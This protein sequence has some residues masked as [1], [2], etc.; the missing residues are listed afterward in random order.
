MKN[1][2]SIRF[3]NKTVVMSLGAAE[4]SSGAAVMIPEWHMGDSKLYSRRKC[5]SRG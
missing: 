5:A 3:Y 1:E 2:N 4:S